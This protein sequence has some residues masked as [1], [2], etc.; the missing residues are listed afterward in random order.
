MDRIGGD[1]WHHLHYS[2]KSNNPQIV[3]R[4]P[5]ALKMILLAKCFFLVLKKFADSLYGRIPLALIG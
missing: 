3:D 1:V 2:E 4:R 5:Y